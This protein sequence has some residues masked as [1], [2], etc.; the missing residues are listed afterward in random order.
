M[1]Q[2]GPLHVR[3]HETAAQ[4]LEPSV[5]SALKTPL[6]EIKVGPIIAKNRAWLVPG[7]PCPGS[8]STEPPA[9]ALELLAFPSSTEHCQ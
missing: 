4:A 9:A 1:W 7:Y 2:D 6:L 3:G 8:L 5:L